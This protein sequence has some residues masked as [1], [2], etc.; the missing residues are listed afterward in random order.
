MLHILNRKMIMMVFEPVHLMV[1]K[2]FW[3]SKLIFIKTADI[4]PFKD[5]IPKFCSMILNPS[6]HQTVPS[7]KI[8]FR[9]PSTARVHINKPCQ[10]SPLLYSFPL[11]FG[12]AYAK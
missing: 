1:K 8:T 10:P 7:Y 2:Q 12:Q 5:K 4:F 9:V 11:L 6:S 3:K